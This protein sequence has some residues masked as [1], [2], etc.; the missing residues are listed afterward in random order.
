LDGRLTTTLVDVLVDRARHN[1]EA[2][3]F[4]VFEFADSDYGAANPRIYSYRELDARARAIAAALRNIVRPGERAL[5]VYPPGAEVLFAFLGCLYAGV[6]AVPINPPRR[7]RP[8][9][10]SRQSPWTPVLV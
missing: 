6:A 7:N 4:G 9:P 10:D 5:L 8:D 3:A 2:T 1:P